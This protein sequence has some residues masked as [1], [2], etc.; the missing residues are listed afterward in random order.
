MIN[1]LYWERGETVDQF[2]TNN[3]CP[4]ALGS[5]TLLVC[6]I[7]GRTCPYALA[8][9]NKFVI[10]ITKYWFSRVTWGKTNVH[11]ITTPTGWGSTG[12]KNKV[13]RLMRAGVLPHG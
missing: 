1:L 8:M 10:G 4:C 2:A 12:L 3:P 13:N 11:D 7:R 6:Q 5:R 9:R